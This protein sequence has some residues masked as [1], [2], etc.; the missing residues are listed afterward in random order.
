[1]KEVDETLDL[2]ANLLS[3]AGKEVTTERVISDGCASEH[4]AVTG[5][6]D[7]QLGRRRGRLVL[8]RA[9]SRTFGGDEGEAGSA[10]LYG[11]GF[12][13]VC[14]SLS[15][16]NNINV[17]K[18]SDILSCRM[19]R[20]YALEGGVLGASGRTGGGR[21]GPPAARSWWRGLGRRR[22][23]PRGGKLMTGCC[24]PRKEKR[25]VRRRAPELRERFP[26]V[27][28]C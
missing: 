13:R 6:E 26:G 28:Y 5:G 21:A 19:L 16:T 17:V 7:A 15:G 4:Q 11:E 10:Q 12:K 24:T 1:V 9:T 20:G 23:A 22:V 2:V 8:V 27:R 14:S 18:I 25:G 3:L